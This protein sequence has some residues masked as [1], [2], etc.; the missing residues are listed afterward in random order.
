MASPTAKVEDADE[1]M[2]RGVADSY[3]TKTISYFKEDG[4]KAIKS[5]A[6]YKTQ[7]S[8]ET[9]DHR[10][11]VIR[12]GVYIVDFSSLIAPKT[13]SDNLFVLPK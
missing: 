3:I 6:F 4:E 5:F 11:N 2:L 8:Q 12:T 13:K 1:K 7:F 10:A 9:M